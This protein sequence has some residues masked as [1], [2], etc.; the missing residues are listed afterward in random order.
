MLVHFTGNA[1]SLA[2]MWWL[3]SLCTR[4]SVWKE[5]RLLRMRNKIAVYIARRAAGAWQTT[6]H[7]RKRRPNLGKPLQKKLLHLRIK[8]SY[9]SS[10]LHHYVWI[11]IF[12]LEV[13]TCPRGSVTIRPHGTQVNRFAMRTSTRPTPFHASTSCPYRTRDA[14]VLFASLLVGG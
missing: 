14:C 5:R 2:M 3:A 4:C 9:P 11:T 6:T 12:P 8:A 7:E 13:C 1:G 10:I